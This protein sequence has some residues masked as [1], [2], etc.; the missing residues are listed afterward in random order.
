MLNETALT[1]NSE[2]NLHLIFHSPFYPQSIAGVVPK[3]R[4][5][6][7]TDRPS[8]KREVFTQKLAEQLADPEKRKQLGSVRVRTLISFLA[9][10]ENKNP[11]IPLS[12][13]K[14]Y[15]PQWKSRKMF[16]S[17]F[18]RDGYLELKKE[19]KQIYFK[20][21]PY[22]YSELVYQSLYPWKVELLDILQQLNK[23]NSYY[24]IKD[25]AF[26]F[27]LLVNELDIE[28][29]DKGAKYGEATRRLML[30]LGIFDDSTIKK[31][32]FRLN[33]ALKEIAGYPLT[34]LFL[35]GNSHTRFGI[36]SYL[37]EYLNFYRRKMRGGAWGQPYRFHRPV[38]PEERRK[39]GRP[40]KTPPFK[41]VSA[42]T[43][44]ERREYT[45]LRC[46]ISNSIARR[47]REDVLDRE[48]KALGKETYMDLDLYG[49]RTL[50]NRLAKL[51]LM[52]SDASHTEEFRNLENQI[53]DSATKRGTRGE[54]KRERVARNRVLP[55]DF[56][57]YE[58][59]VA[60]KDE[61][62]AKG[63]INLKALNSPEFRELEF[64]IRKEARK[65]GKEAELKEALQAEGK[66]TLDC[67][68][69]VEELLDFKEKLIAK[70]ILGSP[71]AETP[72]PPPTPPTPPPP[73]VP[74]TPP[75]PPSPPP[76]D[77]S[78][79]ESKKSP[80]FR[81]IISKIILEANE[82][83]KEEE[84]GAELSAFGL[85]SLWDFNNLEELRAFKQRLIEKG[86]L[87]DPEAPAPDIYQ[88]SGL[89]PPLDVMLGRK[90]IQLA[91]KRGKLD[92]LNQELQA[93]GKSSIDDFESLKGLIRFGK[94]LIEKGIIVGPIEVKGKKFFSSSETK[95]EF[96]GKQ[97]SFSKEKVTISKG[98][99]HSSDFQET[100]REKEEVFDDL[101]A[102][103]IVKQE[104][105]SPDDFF[106]KGEK[107][108]KDNT[109]LYSLPSE[110]KEPEGEKSDEEKG[111]TRLEQE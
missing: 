52:D 39:R 109:P 24:N 12:A 97:S 100:E 33:K 57:S 43:P 15:I 34:P 66:K 96:F 95:R 72:P 41:P 25:I 75:S 73:P 102:G 16:I 85:S 37:R 50:K 65:L 21:T 81:S 64:E 17:T 55:G 10:L 67:F 80:E 70:G 7:A 59:L 111:K 106:H 58:E 48:V 74:P 62:E 8:K 107:N 63:Y 90:I 92:E 20:L 42:L 36:R 69:S 23:T 27:G 89:E 2:D 26:L 79:P 68:D 82:G 94:R 19:G 28:R 83:D 61:M 30:E 38:K 51:G 40:R 87:D 56:Q 1:V 84:V 45:L 71:Q 101:T 98:I 47:H 32:V 105:K 22:A 6:F 44:E 9:L 60:F 46:Y 104:Y 103:Q 35:K 91:T 53:W 93:E 29:K 77:P 49:L 3:V 99:E 108:Q 78:S 31:T 14:P 5:S 11:W 4:K 88:V 86:I 76:I 110:L 54:I 13:L 18:G